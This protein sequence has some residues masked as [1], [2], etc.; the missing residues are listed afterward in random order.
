M[1]KANL[2]RVVHGP[3]FVTVP[4]P[5]CGRSNKWTYEPDE[6]PSGREAMIN[7]K[8]TCDGEWVGYSCRCRVGVRYDFDVKRTTHVTHV[9]PYRRREG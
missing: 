3:P 4:C 1:N 9:V 8:G 7:D 6:T 5:V 2:V